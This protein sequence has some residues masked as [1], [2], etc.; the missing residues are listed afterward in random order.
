MNVMMS[1]TKEMNETKKQQNKLETR[2]GHHRLI[3]QIM[4][5]WK[6]H[7]PKYFKNHKSIYN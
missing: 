3:N 5:L 2:Q 1:R 4:L 6:D 7:Y